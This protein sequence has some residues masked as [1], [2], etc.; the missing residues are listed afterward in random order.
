MARKES[1][2]AM[3]PARGGSKGIPRKNIVELEGYPLIA[4]TIRAAKACREI[5]RVVVTTDDHEIAAIAETF[6]AEPLLRPREISG[7]DAS[8]FLATG[9]ALHKL[10]TAEGYEPTLKITMLPT[11]PFRDPGKLDRAL[12]SVKKREYKG[13]ACCADPPLANR[14]FFRLKGSHARPIRFA[15][16]DGEWSLASASFSCSRYHPYFDPLRV[17][18]ERIYQE[19]ANPYHRR[20]ENL[21]IQTGPIR[22]VKLSPMQSIDIDRPIDLALARRV[23]KERMFEPW[24]L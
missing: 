22:F 8:L 17:R 18:P 15:H 11:Y 1:A 24:Y 19:V 9:H 12:V 23:L 7:D 20:L 5:D 6:G 13:I 14:L 3:I 16:P 4:Y 10:R 2:L 21:G